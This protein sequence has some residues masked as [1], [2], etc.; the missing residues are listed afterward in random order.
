MFRLIPTRQLF[1]GPYSG[2]AA[3]SGRAVFVTSG[4]RLQAST[5]YSMSMGKIGQSWIR[6]VLGENGGIG[7]AFGEIVWIV[8]SKGP[9]FR[10][11]EAGRI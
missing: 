5:L 3:R 9:R 4:R 10:G 7:H 2:A 1:P 6:I 8:R 11:E